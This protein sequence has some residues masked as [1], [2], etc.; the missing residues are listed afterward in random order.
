MMSALVLLAVYLVGVAGYVVIVPDVTLFESMYLV[1]IT[2]ST[3]GFGETFELGTAGRLW[4]GVIIVFGIFAVVSAFGSLTAMVVEGEVGRLIGSRKLEARISKMDGHAIVCGFGRMG[5]QVVELL[6][7]RNVPV[8]VVEREL[9]QS[10]EV[11]QINQL[12]IVGDATEEHTL[13]RAGIARAKYLVAV[14]ASDADNVF[15]T[16]SARELR[17]DMYIVARAEHPASQVKLRRAGA[18]R[19]ILPQRIGAE[20]IANLLTRPHL[21]DFVDVAAKGVELEMD[22]FLVTSNSPMAGKSLRETDLRQ[23]ANVM[24]IAIKSGE[25]DTRFNPGADEV[26]LPNDTLIMIGEAGA[27]ARLAKMQRLEQ[28]PEE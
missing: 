7:E 13:E 17:P 2:L 1:L 23:A 20:R 26:L 6:V 12:Y 19:V 21:V 18:N 25:G 22:E 4:T 15:V 27:A 10:R 5:R 14:L 16:L 11:E 9:S 24:V 28:A 3:V 8:V